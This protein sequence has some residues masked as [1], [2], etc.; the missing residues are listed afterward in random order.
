MNHGDKQLN[1][2]GVYFRDKIL[3]IL[4][5]VFPIVNSLVNA[6][7]DS[8]HRSPVSNGLLDDLNPM[9]CPMIS[10][11]ILLPSLR[12]INKHI[13]NTR[14]HTKCRLGGMWNCCW[15]CPR[16]EVSKCTCRLKT[17]N[18]KIAI[19]WRIQIKAISRF[20]GSPQLMSKTMN[21]QVH[22]HDQLML[23]SLMQSFVGESSIRF[24]PLCGPVCYHRLHAQTI[25][26]DM[27][28]PTRATAHIHIVLAVDLLC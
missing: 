27:H 5:M 17:W 19:D 8:G 4:A 25:K 23:P 24:C 28:T 6:A 2:G 3:G 10:V 1:L 7:S 14:A 20:L 21:L 13:P 12:L 11:A 9:L 16:L 18:Q 15:P 26:Y 22:I